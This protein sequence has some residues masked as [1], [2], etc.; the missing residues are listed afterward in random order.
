MKK[1]ES[2]GLHKE[3][4]KRQSRSGVNCSEL[5]FISRMR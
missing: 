2:N 1:R 4:E 5:D 3:M